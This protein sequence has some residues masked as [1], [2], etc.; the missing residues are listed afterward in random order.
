[1][2]HYCCCCFLNFLKEA[3]EKIRVL[4]VEVAKEMKLH[5]LENNLIEKIKKDPYFEK[6][7][8]EL[9]AILDTSTFIGCAPKQVRVIYMKTK[10]ILL[11][12]ILS[13]LL[14]FLILFFRFPNF[15]KIT[16]MMW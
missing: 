8:P 16:F 2:I 15:C 14:L 10:N 12:D 6:I 5:G 9:P 4:S 3:H 7:L 13:Y 1:M 11:F